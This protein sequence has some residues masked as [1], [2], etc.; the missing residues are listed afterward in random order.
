M[1]FLVIGHDGRD[2]GALARRLAARDD[3]LAGARALK[4]QGRFINGGALL[5]EQGQMIGS[6]MVMDFPDRAALDAWIARD[7]YT[8]GKVWQRVEVQPLRLALLDAPGP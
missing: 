4:A 3:H 2:E 5:D 6:A 7:P 1:Q 8:L